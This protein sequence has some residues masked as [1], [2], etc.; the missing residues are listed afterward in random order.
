MRRF[1]VLAGL[2]A[3]LLAAPLRAVAICIFDGDCPAGQICA[4]GVCGC[5]PG[6]YVWMR[7]GIVRCR[8]CEAGCACPGAL[9][10]CFGCSA[11]QHSPA[12]DAIACDLCPAGTTSDIIL[13]T[14]CDPD[15]YETPCANRHGPLGQIA[16][17]PIPPPQNIT[18]VAPNG[19]LF[20]VAQYEPGGPPYIPRKV[21]PYYD[22][23]G[24]PRV[25]QSG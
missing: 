8:V 14:G 24:L 21:S 11:G 4:A 2:L 7:D 18:F 19:A 20:D 3:G 17:R 15:N 25:Q 12:P 16:C 6:S 1:S 13:N 22:I 5:R 10:P 9:K 23:D